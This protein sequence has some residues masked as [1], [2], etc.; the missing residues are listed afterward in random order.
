MIFTTLFSRF[1][2]GTRLHLW[3]LITNTAIFVNI[4][5]RLETLLGISML[6][7]RNSRAIS[8]MIPV[9]AAHNRWNPLNPTKCKSY[10]GSVDVSTL[11]PD[12]WGRRKPTGRSAGDIFYVWCTRK[13]SY[14]CHRSLFDQEIPFFFDVNQAIHTP[15]NVFWR[16]FNSWPNIPFFDWLIWPSHVETME[17]LTYVKLF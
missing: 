12:C 10:F 3:E 17:G 5:E 6:I 9:S 13:R 2:D 14:F 8:R 11:R 7:D 15:W 1:P 16:L 4:F